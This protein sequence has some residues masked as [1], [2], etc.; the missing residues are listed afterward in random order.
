MRPITLDDIEYLRVWKN[1]N[2]EYFFFKEEIT[3]ED[4]LNWYNRFI[5]FPDNYMF[6]I[7]NENEKIGC[8]G[9]RLFQGFADVYNV[10]LGNNIYKGKHVM[11]NAIE[12][13][14]ALCSLIYKDIPI[15]VRVLNNNPAIQW[16]QKIGFSLS[17]SFE[18]YTLMNYEF[19]TLRKKYIYKIEI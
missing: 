15:C 10:I 8:I 7:E 17:D 19:K 9:V 12:A 3:K 18:E 5:L 2:K 16:Y 6:I 4:Q 13:I 1:L 11:T 14:I